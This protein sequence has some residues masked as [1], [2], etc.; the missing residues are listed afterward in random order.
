MRSEKLLNAIG[1]INDT[2]ITDAMA[3][4]SKMEKPKVARWIKYVAMAACLCLIFVL[5][6]AAAQSELFV[7]IFTDMTGWHIQAREYYTDRDFSKEV[8]TLAKEEAGA[9]TYYP[10]ETLE[11]VEEFLGIDLPHNPLLTEEIRDE[12]HIETEVNGQMQRYDSHCLLRLAFSEDGSVLAADTDVAYRY[13][14]MSLQVLYRIP[15]E[16][17]TFKGGGGIGGIDASITE[18]QTFTTSSGREY[19]VICNN[20][21]EGIFSCLGYTVVDRVLV[22]VSLVGRSEE[23]MRQAVIEVLEA[24]E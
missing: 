3:M 16:D 8:R 19:A 7:D 11:E 20:A 2:L 1:N 18:A 13:G 10:A 23:E 21:G 15:T 24:Y 6:I 9:I 17:A 5:P 22:Q 4:P 14:I 12:V